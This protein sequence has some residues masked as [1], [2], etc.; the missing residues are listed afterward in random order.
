V[1]IFLTFV[2]GIARHEESCVDSCAIRETSAMSEVAYFAA[3]IRFRLA[4]V[5]ARSIERWD[6]VR[7]I[8]LFKS[9]MK[10]ARAAEV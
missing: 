7:A 2:A 4:S 8:G 6:A 9:R 1:C 5:E 10:K 3:H